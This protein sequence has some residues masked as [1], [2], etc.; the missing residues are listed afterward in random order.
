MLSGPPGSGKTMLANRLTKDDTN[1]ILHSYDDIPGANT[2]TSS[3][4]IVRQ[5]WLTNIKRDLES[6]KNVVIDHV[7]LTSDKRVNLLNE[8]KEFDCDKILYILTTPLEECLKR[9][10][11][12][13]GVAKLPE[14]IVTSMYDRFQHP[15]MDEGWTDIVY[16]N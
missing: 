16:V 15:S 6:G 11:S 2:L 13:E 1:T 9:N 12:R 3:V 10:S 7:N 8:F 4:K 5:T 14:F